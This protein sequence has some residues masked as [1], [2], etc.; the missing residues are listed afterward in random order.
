MIQ[1]FVNQ[2]AHV[3]I[4]QYTVVFFTNNNE[5]TSPKGRALM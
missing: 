4:K 2:N 3:Y 1:C 5:N